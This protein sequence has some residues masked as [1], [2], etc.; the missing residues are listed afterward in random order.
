VHLS[1]GQAT[2]NTT[3]LVP[4]I[5]KVSLF[6]TFATGMAMVDTTKKIRFGFDEKACGLWE[7]RG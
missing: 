4:A 1:G 7:Q 2:P 5:T 6:F 3:F